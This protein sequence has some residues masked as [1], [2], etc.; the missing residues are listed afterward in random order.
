MTTPFS[1]PLGLYKATPEMLAAEKRWPLKRYLKAFR[2]G[3]GESFF[4]YDERHQLIFIPK[5]L[6][7]NQPQNPNVL[8]SWGRA[9]REL[10]DSKLKHKFYQTLKVFLESY[11]EGFME[12]FSESFPKGLPNDPVPVPVNDTV[13]DTVLD[14]VTDE[15]QKDKIPYEAIIED[16]NHVFDSGYKPDTSETKKL[17]RARWNEGFTLDDFKLVHR[18]MKKAWGSNSKMAEF[19]RP[20]TLYTGKFDSY[21]NRIETD[22][23][24]ARHELISEAL[25]E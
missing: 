3:L 20:Q 16:F 15:I 4:E 8:K 13:L 2:E 12:A 23:I 19:L 21:L 7:Y 5:F 9:Y 18:K 25:E 11:G 6:K 14:T 17:I 22:R 1:S 10:P 24:N